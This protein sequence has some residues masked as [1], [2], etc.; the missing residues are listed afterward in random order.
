MT[1]SLFSSHTDARALLQAR[2]LFNAGDLPGAIEISERFMITESELTKARTSP[3]DKM[4]FYELN[5]SLVKSPLMVIGWSISEPYLIAVINETIKNVIQRGRL[6]ELSIIDPVFNTR[7]HATATAC[8][9]LPREQ[10]FAEL[11]THPG[12]IGADEFFLWLQA[13]YAMDN[14][15]AHAADGARAALA[16]KRAELGG[17]TNDHFLIEWIDH[18]LPAWTRLCW[19][20]ELAGC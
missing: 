16:A 5:S 8:Y 12:G 13:R 11:E 3:T 14:L 17:P 1:F 15:V 7:G 2:D 18:F 20:A 4:F 6:E 9:E 19:R 10:V